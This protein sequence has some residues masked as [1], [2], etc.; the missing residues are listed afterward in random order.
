MDVFL[1]DE[2]LFTISDTDIKLLAHDLEDPISE[3]KR[4]LE[5]I[6]SHKCDQCY[7]RMRDEWVERFEKT[8]E[9][10]A[11]PLG[12]DAFVALVTA[13]PDY[14]DRVERELAQTRLA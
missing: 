14:K 1:D 4:R 13:H 2:K 7:K 5:Y 10:S 12:R 3:I 6:I 9:I 8:G 11:V